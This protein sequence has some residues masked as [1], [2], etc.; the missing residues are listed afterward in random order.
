METEDILTATIKLGESGLTYS[1]SE[2]IAN[3][4]V[5]A[6]K[7]LATKDDLEFGIDSLKEQMVTKSDLNSLKEQMMTKADLESAFGSLKIW[8]LLILLGVHGS[9]LAIIS[10]MAFTWLNFGHP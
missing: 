4:I 9:T 6:V 1:Q 2:A 10:G 3:T 5:A 8:L 7:P